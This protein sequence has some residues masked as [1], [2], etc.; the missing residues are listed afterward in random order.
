MSKVLPHDTI[1]TLQKR[2]TQQQKTRGSNQKPIGQHKPRERSSTEGRQANSTQHSDTPRTST[3]IE[4]TGTKMN[5][6]DRSETTPI[7]KNFKTW[8]TKKTKPWMVNQKEI[9]HLSQEKD[10]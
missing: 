3:P 8:P 5:K 9:Q 7:Q 10:H 4:S 1:Q 6:A 2:L